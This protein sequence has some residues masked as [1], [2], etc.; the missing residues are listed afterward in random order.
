MSNLEQKVADKS[1][2][3]IEELYQNNADYR[4][5]VDTQADARAAIMK[6]EYMAS[7]K[8]D[9]RSQIVDEK[10]LDE[11]FKTNAQNAILE[12]AVQN[13]IKENKSTKEYSSLQEEAIN[14]A[15]LAATN[16]FWPEAIKYGLVNT[17]GFRKYLYTAPTSVTQKAMR[18][19]KGLKEITTSAGRKR[20]ATDIGKTLTR[21]EKWKQFGK[22]AGS[23]MWGGAWTNGS[24]D[25]MVD[26]AER[27]NEDSF[28][29]YL[30]DYETGE[31][32]ADTYG[33]VD[34]LFSYWNGLQNSLGQDTTLEAGIVGALGSALSGN[35][36]F[37]NIASLATK[38][39]R[40]AFR[41]NFQ[42]RYKRDAD[43]MIIRG[44]D[45]KAETENISWR[46]NW[47]DRL[48][49]FIQNGVLNTYYEKKQQLRN[50]QAHADFVNNI[51]DD[52]DDFKGIESLI[53]SNI[54]RENA[55]NIGDEKT[56]RFV[57]A[58][59]AINTL[60]NLGRDDK[61]PSTLSSVV[62]QHKDMIE[63]ASKLGTEESDM[64]EE[65]ITNL[66][67]QYYSNNPGLAQTEENNQIALQNIAQ[68][69]RKLQ[70]AYQAFNEA[71]KSI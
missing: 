41:N 68:N 14:S 4:K 10:K 12:E 25:M 5:A 48:A 52:L 58:F 49:F 61:D 44:E 47:G 7:L 16:T 50:L 36:H 67:G 63:R 32:T 11:Y 56:M 1:G 59:N 55:L 9:G 13:K 45:G 64:N 17:I 20:L 35:L 24:D 19:F 60:E 65:E 62:M 30:H 46:E 53:S 40:E 6:A 38:E 54:G 71:E 15:G 26:A 22:A 2:K 3:E 18:N 43:G 66:L 57:Q 29:R 23:Q 51:L 69:A 28:N 39:G 37:T 21:A 31:S 34:G 70:E 33:F 27:I 8:Q 42:Q